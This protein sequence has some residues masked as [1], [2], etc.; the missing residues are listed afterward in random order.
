VCLPGLAALCIAIGPAPSAAAAR[1]T[2]RAHREAER[3]QASAA[4]ADDAPNDPTD[5][6]NHPDSND[7]GMTAF[8]A[9]A[10]AKPTEIGSTTVVV[11]LAAPFQPAGSFTSAF[12]SR[13]DDVPD[14]GTVMHRR[15]H[16]PNAPPMV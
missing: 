2:D 16:F 14:C 12:L 4:D 7:G 11:G 8:V 15:P 10:S 6:P 1:L 5:A 3:R 9:P 13:F